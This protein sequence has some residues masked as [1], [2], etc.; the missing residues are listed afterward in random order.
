MFFFYFCIS[1]L[2]NKYKFLILDLYEDVSE[3]D[4]I[5]ES[6]SGKKKKCYFEGNAKLKQV[7]HVSCM[8]NILQPL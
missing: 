8:Y 7:L 5:A 6:V 2:Q 3:T 1:S 4:R